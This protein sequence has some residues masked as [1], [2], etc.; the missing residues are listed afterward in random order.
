MFT[1]SKFPGKKGNAHSSVCK[2]NTVSKMGLMGFCRASA[3]SNQTIFLCSSSPT[4]IL[5]IKLRDES[6]ALLAMRAFITNLSLSSVLASRLG[7]YTGLWISLFF[8]YFHY[9][10]LPTQKGPNEMPPRFLNRLSSLQFLCMGSLCWRG[11]FFSPQYPKE[12]MVIKT[13]NA[14]FLRLFFS[15]VL[16]YNNQIHTQMHTRTPGS[17]HY[18]GLKMKCIFMQKSDVLSPEI[19]EATDLY[20]INVPVCQREQRGPTRRIGELVFVPCADNYRYAATL[21]TT[22]RQILRA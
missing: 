7:S 10:S 15:L 13:I 1:C 20:M 12:H 18:A 14:A 2:E 3:G 16:N 11:P 22:E 19:T 17:H 9:R 4:E 6:R 8:V 5:S 21:R